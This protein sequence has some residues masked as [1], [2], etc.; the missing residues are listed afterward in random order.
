MIAIAVEPARLKLWCRGQGA[1]AVLVQGFAESVVLSDGPEAGVSVREVVEIE[2][3]VGS[4]GGGVEA[5]G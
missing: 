2:R 3:W 4:R 1:F 5:A